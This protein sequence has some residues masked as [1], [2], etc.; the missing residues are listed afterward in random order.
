MPTLSGLKMLSSDDLVWPITYRYVAQGGRGLTSWELTV[1]VPS[2]E[3]DRDHSIALGIP[4]FN[5][6]IATAICTSIDLLY[7]DYVI[8]KF[9]PIPGISGSGGARGLRFGTPAPRTKTACLTFNTEHS[10]SYGRRQHY[11]YGMPFTWQDGDFLTGSG[12]SGA[13]GYAHL[14][15]TG[16]HSHFSSGSMQHLIAYFGVV[17]PAVG[18]FWG[19]GFRRVASYNVFQYV[20]KAPELSASLWPPSAS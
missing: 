1:D 20:D 16:M 12:W 14:L 13:M 3:G 4:L 5:N 7:F 17:P 19:V 9:S 10:D 2:L 6:T 15:A 11:L 8:H 18:N